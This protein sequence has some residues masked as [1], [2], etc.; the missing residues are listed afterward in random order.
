MI[1]LNNNREAQSVYIPKRN[2][3]PGL[4]FPIIG[5]LDIRSTIDNA[6]Y[7]MNVQIG[8]NHAGY[9]AVSLTLPSGVQSG[10]YEYALY[11]VRVGHDPLEMARGL[12]TIWPDTVGP[13]GLEYAQ[14]ESAAEWEQYDNEQ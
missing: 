2:D 10:E 3:S 8:M 11:M 12:C 9:Y 6:T 14:H 5:L 13:E 1:Y 7:R 4:D